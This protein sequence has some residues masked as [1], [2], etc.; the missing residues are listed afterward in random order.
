[1]T[2]A[3]AAVL[4]AATAYGAAMA[5]SRPPADEAEP[6]AQPVPRANVA[7]SSSW[8]SPANPAPAITAKPRRTERQAIFETV[9]QPIGANGP[10]VPPAERPSERTAETEVAT[11]AE[12]PPDG[13][14]VIVYTTS[15][16]SVC[17]HAKQWLSAE[18][19]PFEEHDVERSTESARTLRAL[20]P[21]GSIPT[22]DIEG[23]VLV[24]FREG[25]VL[26]AMRRASERRRSRVPW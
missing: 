22:F 15:W 4:V 16:C 25:D 23:Q 17:K 21:R 5:R 7:V 12:R 18:Q 13:V 19:I 24:G 8:A 6:L 11:V 1:M 20:N 10:S 26:A 3:V 9:A 14:Q 2:V